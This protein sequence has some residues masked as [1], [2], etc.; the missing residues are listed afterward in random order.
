MT[1]FTNSFLIAL[2]ALMIT[3]S[4]IYASDVKPPDLAGSWYPA[5]KEELTKLLRGYLDSA[6][7]ETIEGRIF[8]LISPHAG[9]QFSG[10][11]AAYGF[12]LASSDSVK[13]VI[14][15]GFS[16]RKAFDGIAIYDRGAFG[17]PLGDVAVDSQLAA[18][19][20]AQ[21]KR[22]RFYPE[23][24]SGEN[25]IEMQVPFI[26]LAFPGASIV[27]I[28][29]G[30]QDYADAETLATALETALRG[31]KD[32]LVVAST[33]LSHYHPYDEANSIDRQLISDLE[34]MKAGKI[35][36][37][38]KLGKCEACGIMPIAATLLAAQK[39]GF[40][41]IKI[42][43]YANSGDTSGDKSGVVGYVSAAIYESA[44]SASESPKEEGGGGHMLL[45]DSQ[46]KRLL[47]IA[48]ESITSYVGSGNRAN[49]TENDPALERPFGAFVTLKENGD[50]RGCIGNMTAQGPLYRT[51]ADM[52]VEAATGDPRFP[53]L[54]PREIDK[55]DIEIS[56]LSPL[57]K[58][59]DTDEI[60]IPG[61]G[62]LVR[63]GGRS[64]VYLPQV[65]T[66]AGWDKEEFMTSLCAHKA[67]LAPDAWKDPSTD[68]YIF[69][70]EVFGEEGRRE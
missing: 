8:A 30:T 10:P 31:R 13:T 21:E 25:S 44:G 27:P 37:D 29:F 24:F 11:V 1:A 34:E 20:E 52:A 26:Q 47:E 46:R 35:Y 14:I 36:E 62:V 38:V 65:A 48:R 41:G 32:C 57:K 63:R 56:V 45:N 4:P 17:T 55:V 6:E 54:S 28:A 60:R 12:K 43:K 40:N 33:D 18:S 53:S 7:P 49:F 16:H 19:I 2:L 59:A 5:S 9:Y 15:I 70:A 66:E 51:V 58:I 50:L 61:H 69:E 23:A 42:L 22:I 3:F 39:L 64:G 68:V 67:G